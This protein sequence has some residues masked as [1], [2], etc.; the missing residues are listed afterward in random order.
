[1]GRFYT[2]TNLQIDDKKAH[3]VFDGKKLAK[4]GTDK[5]PASIVVQTEAREAELSALFAENRW[6]VVIEV[7]EERAEDLSDLELLQNKPETTML[8]KLPGR[9]DPCSCGSGKKFKKCCA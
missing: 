3:K 2:Q 7:D 5:N 4:L 6:S 8:N 1:M 9:N